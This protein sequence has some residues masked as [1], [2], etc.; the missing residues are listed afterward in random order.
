MKTDGTYLSQS[1]QSLVLYLSYVSGF[2]H[3]FVTFCTLLYHTVLYSV[4]LSRKYGNLRC[5]F[6]RSNY[7]L[8]FV[9]ILYVGPSKNTPSNAE[10]LGAGSKQH[11]SNSSYRSLFHFCILYASHTLSIFSV[12]KYGFL[13]ILRL[14]ISWRNF[15]L[16]LSCIQCVPY[17]KNG[18]LICLILFSGAPNHQVRIRWRNA[19]LFTR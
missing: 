15:S 2:L 16:F 14:F 12:I 5:A 3:L 17:E 18:V 7:K 19:T 8:L 13:N 4:C 6:D 9:Y 1:E 10:I 11:R